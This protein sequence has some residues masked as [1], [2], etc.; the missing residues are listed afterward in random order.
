MNWQDVQKILQTLPRTYQRFGPNWSNWLNSQTAP[1]TRFTTSFDGITTQADY[2][3]AVGSW[4][5][6]WGEILGILRGA[7]NDALYRIC[8][9][10][11][12]TAARGTPVGIERYINIA[13]QIPCS[14]VENFP[15]VG[16]QLALESGFTLTASQQASLPGWLSLVRP[17]GIPYSVVGYNSNGVLSSGN[18]LSGTRFIGSWM[19]T[20][21]SNVP[22]TIPTSTNSTTCLLPTTL[23][24]DQ[25]INPSLVTT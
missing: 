17:A 16:W 13:R 10:F 7:E 23:F 6:A 19:R 12:L 25:T 21:Q 2:V 4:L 14:V 3:S 20:S 15:A 9:T 8:I 18:Y 5:N 24:T 11:G 1:L 22:L